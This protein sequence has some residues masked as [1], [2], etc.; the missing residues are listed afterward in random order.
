[1]TRT[2]L[3]LQWP[4][5]MVTEECGTFKSLAKNSMQAWLGAGLARPSRGRE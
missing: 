1:M 4:D 3:L 5:A 2:I